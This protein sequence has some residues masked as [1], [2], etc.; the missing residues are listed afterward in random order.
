MSERDDEL[1]EGL[2]SGS[3]RK[4]VPLRSTWITRIRVSRAALIWTGILLLSVFFLIGRRRPSRR[5]GHPQT[6]P[7]S[8]DEQR[9]WAQYS[10]YHA[11]AEYQPPPAGCEVTQV[12]SVLLVFESTL[13]SLRRT[14]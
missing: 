7:V 1:E 4:D 2:L 8:E 5:D 10:P 12:S 9:K 3:N 6:L 11:L 13:I 14:S